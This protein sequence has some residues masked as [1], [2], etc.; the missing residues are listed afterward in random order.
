MSK[1]KWY[2]ITQVSRA[3]GVSRSR[4]YQRLHCDPRV[5]RGAGRFLPHKVVEHGI[6]VGGNAQGTAHYLVSESEV[7]A[8]RAERV[9]RGLRVGELRGPNE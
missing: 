2:T 6:P 4:I 5:K 3:V 7:I 1:T 8:W 9:L